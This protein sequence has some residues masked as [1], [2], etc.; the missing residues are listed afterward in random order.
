ML[1]KHYIV[2]PEPNIECNMEK[3]PEKEKIETS[4][5]QHEQ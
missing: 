5:F 1:T 2:D 4:T 3:V